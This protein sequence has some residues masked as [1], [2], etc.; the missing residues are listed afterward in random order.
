MTKLKRAVAAVVQK[1]NKILLCR[2]GFACRNQP[3]KWENAGGG[4]ED[5]ETNEE[6]IKREIKEELGVEFILGKILNED[7]FKSEDTDW[8]VVLFEGSI[9]DSPKI[10]EKDKLIEFAWFDKSELDKIDLASYTKLDFIKLGW[11]KE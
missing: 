9:V 7:K 6:A 11:V 4:V 5:G 8:Q 10:M 1:D 3:G 2:R